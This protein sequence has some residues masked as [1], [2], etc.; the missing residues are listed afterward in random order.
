MAKCPHAQGCVLTQGYGMAGPGSNDRGRPA[1]HAVT[2]IWREMEML[3][4]LAV[5]L[6][7]EEELMS[8]VLN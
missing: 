2:G 5:F 8:T 6:S 4:H 7:V 1:M 3:M